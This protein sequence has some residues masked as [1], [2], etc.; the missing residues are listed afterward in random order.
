[1]LFYPV[2]LILFPFFW[3][4]DRRVLPAFRSFKGCSGSGWAAEEA[5]HQPSP[6]GA[7]DAE[8]DFGDCGDVDFWG[9]GVPRFVANLDRSQVMWV[10]KMSQ[11]SKS[12][13]DQKWDDIFGVWLRWW[14]QVSTIEGRFHGKYNVVFIWI[15]M[16]QMLMTHDMIF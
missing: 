1:M 2:V 11:T 5:A 8:D 13:R 9:P 3:G 7:I 16:I 14:L 10:P 12:H 6:L 4:T 15:N